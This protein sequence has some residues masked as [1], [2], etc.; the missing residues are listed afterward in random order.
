MIIQ[1][2]NKHKCFFY[3]FIIFF[4]NGR[5]MIKLEHKFCM[6]KKE[7]GM[8]QVQVGNSTILR[9]VRFAVE[10]IIMNFKSIKEIIN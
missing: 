8:W 3:E 9:T 1:N 2:F 5:N 4:V 10:K 6:T 7:A